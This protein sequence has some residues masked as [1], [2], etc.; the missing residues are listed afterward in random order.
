MLKELIEPD[1][2]ICQIGG[3]IMNDPVTIE[4]GMTYDR[5]SITTLWKFVKEAGND[6]K[7]P[8]TNQVVNPDILLENKN[9]KIEI[10]RFYEENPWSF[11][12]DPRQKFSDISILED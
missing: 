1:Y 11:D 9:L 2:I 10:E 7:C 12:F 4:T 5:S 8:V 3:F 6:Y